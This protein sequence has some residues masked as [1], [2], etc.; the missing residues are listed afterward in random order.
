MKQRAKQ[1]HRNK[2]D[3]AFTNRV[4]VRHTYHNT[5]TE[6]LTF[7]DDAVFIINDY[8]VALWWVHQRDQYHQLVEAEA[9]RRINHLRPEVDLFA[10]TIPN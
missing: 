9:L 8:R 2:R 5:T 6:T 7:W 1:Y 10:D 4:I 3:D